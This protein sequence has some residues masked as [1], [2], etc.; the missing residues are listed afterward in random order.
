MSSTEE[1][2]IFAKSS[3]KSGS[4]K[5]SN[6]CVHKLGFVIAL[7]LCL[8]AVAPVIFFAVKGALGKMAENETTAPG[9][10]GTPQP[11][12]SLPQ[13]LTCTKPVS[14]DRLVFNAA[15]I[16]STKFG[17]PLYANN[18]TLSITTAPHAGYG[19][20]I[21]A[22]PFIY[23]SAVAG[24]G[25]LTRIT[26]TTEATAKYTLDA[27]QVLTFKAR[28]G[29]KI[30]QPAV[31]PAYIDDPDDYRNGEL[32]MTSVMEDF[33]LVNNIILTNKAVYA[34]YEVPPFVWYASGR[35]NKV[36]SFSSFYKLMDRQ[37]SDV[38]DAQIIYDRKHN[39]IT[40][41]VDGNMVSVDQPGL[42]PGK[43]YE[44]GKSY[45][46]QFQNV[47]YHTPEGGATTKANDASVWTNQFGVG[48][49]IINFMDGAP[50]A[51][52]GNNTDLAGIV[53]LTGLPYALPKRW[54]Y[55]TLPNNAQLTDDATYNPFY[56]QGAAL[57]LY[58]QTVSINGC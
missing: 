10:G 13:Y 57:D 2:P 24:K 54:S 36:S 28:I 7:V 56:G 47:V 5:S 1:S 23:N 45:N 6:E 25:E 35:N 53:P 26:Y 11:D 32:S 52:G 3:K 55:A 38:H 37:P 46:N 58:E 40:F 41:V 49:G 44:D 43:V 48:Y 22:N 31:I 51:P 21:T 50:L 34:L 18:G 29:G 39:Q 27:D 8:A 15:S 14:K 19:L 17:T 9:T 30:I 4:K 12:S 33:S 20:R 42:Q 16:M